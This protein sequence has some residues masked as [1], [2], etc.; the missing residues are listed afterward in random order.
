MSVRVNVVF[1][2]WRLASGEESLL[3]SL[4]VVR[5]GCCVPAAASQV[6]TS[7]WAGVLFVCV[8]ANACA[9]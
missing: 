2:P 6:W 3:P 9:A 1:S 7:C 8:I 4:V 5:P